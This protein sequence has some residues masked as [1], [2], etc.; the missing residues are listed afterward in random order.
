MDR[1]VGVTNGWFA[2]SLNFM[3]ARR[4][5]FL[6]VVPSPSIHALYHPPQLKLNKQGEQLKTWMGCWSLSIRTQTLPTRLLYLQNTADQIL[7]FF[8]FHPI[9]F[10]LF[11]CKSQN[12]SLFSAEFIFSLGLFIAMLNKNAKWDHQSLDF[13]TKLKIEPMYEIDRITLRNLI[14]WEQNLI[15]NYFYRQKRLL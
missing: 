4:R 12:R 1:Q 14:T 11:L 2:R 15:K 5:I 13:V 6:A 3:V 8:L 9:S 7:L 10:I